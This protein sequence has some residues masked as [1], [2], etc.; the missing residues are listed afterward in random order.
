MKLLLPFLLI[1]IFFSSYSQKNIYKISKRLSKCQ[2]DRTGNF[3]KMTFYEVRKLALKEYFNLF[4]NVSD[5]VFFLEKYDVEYA[6]YY[7]RIW[8]ENTSFNY[9]F[10][11]NKVTV[12]DKNFFTNKTTDFISSWDTL[13]IRNEEILYPNQ[14]KIIYGSRCLFINN[15]YQINTIILRDLLFDR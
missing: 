15:R 9:K 2:T 1:F 7:G 5:T 12:S 4:Y 8:Y 14:P 6:T 10:F 11:A 13:G 3:K